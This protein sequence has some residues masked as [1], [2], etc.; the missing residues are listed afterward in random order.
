MISRRI[1]PVG[2]RDLLGFAATAFVAAI[3]LRLARAQAT[4][5]A[6][7]PVERLDNACSRR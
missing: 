2:R 7:A 5:P 6:T 1:C 4:S 3:P